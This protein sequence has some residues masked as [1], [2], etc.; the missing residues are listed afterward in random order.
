MPPTHAPGSDDPAR[1]EENERAIPSCA[2]ARRGRRHPHRVTRGIE[3]VRDPGDPAQSAA[4]SGL[5]APIIARSPWYLQIP[6]DAFRSEEHTSELQSPC[7]IVC[8]L[9]LE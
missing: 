7:N 6:L 8:R 5:L 4:Q 1:H 2:Y 9:L 3:A